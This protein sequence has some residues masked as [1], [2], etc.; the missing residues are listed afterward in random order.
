MTEELRAGLS[1][2]A[3][4]TAERHLFLCIGPDCCAS[5]DGEA[6]WEYVK[7]RV[8]ETGLRAMRTKAGCFRICTGGPWLVVYPEGTWYGSVTA[9]RFERVLQEHLLGG[10]RIREWLVAEN[11]LR[12]T[13]SS[14][15]CEIPLA[16]LTR[17]P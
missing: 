9:E 5:A 8:R 13:G 1:K 7:R 6:L 16:A 11:G 17:R 3:I 4:A 10:E 12:A 15:P 2:A 14:A